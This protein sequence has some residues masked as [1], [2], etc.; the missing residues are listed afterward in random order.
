MCVMKLAACTG[1]AAPLYMLCIEACCMHKVCCRVIGS[2]D[3]G[4]FKEGAVLLV[5]RPS[6]LLTLQARFRPVC[7][8][9][10]IKYNQMCIILCLMRFKTCYNGR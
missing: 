2:L 3:G 6:T 7:S 5:S 9:T 10:F 1:D 8:R 4:M